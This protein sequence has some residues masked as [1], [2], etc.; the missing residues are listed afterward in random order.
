MSEPSLSKGDVVL[1]ARAVVKRFPGIVALD[2]VTFRAYRNQV[3]VLIGENGAGKS[4]LMRILAGV[5][6]ADEGE[7]L[8]DGR[9]I[10]MQSPRDATAHGISIV[11]QELATFANLNIS[12]NI[13]AGRELRR[14]AMFV[15]EPR[16][17]ARSE[18]AL[19]RL[20][21]PMNVATESASLPLGCR[22]V[23]EIARSLDQGSRILILD[24]P[25]SA[26][27]TAE[28]ESL[29]DVIAHLK[30]SGVTI[31]YISHRLHELLHLGDQFTVLRSGRVVGEASRAEVT[32]QWIVERMSGR[33]DDETINQEREVA[34]RPVVLSV[35]NL[36]LRGSVGAEDSQVALHGLS[37]SVREGEILGIYG[38]LGAGRTELLEALAGFRRMDDGEIEIRGKTMRIQNVRSALRAGIALL[39]EDRQRDGL[40]QDLSIRENVI[41]SGKRGIFLSQ[42]GEIARVQKLVSELRIATN[43]LELPVTTL[44]GGN[45]QKVL[46]ARCLMCSPKVLLLDEPTRGIDV[47]AKSEIYAILRRLAGKGIG[48]IFASSEIEETRSLAN[49]VLVLC[50]GR[51]AA[52]LAREEATDER[53]FAAA[54]PTVAAGESAAERM[55]LPERIA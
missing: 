29:L 21:M 19:R 44:S 34:L 25:T 31:I 45:Q 40:F 47:G 10:Q 15:D 2:G 48:I 27:S 36:S 53:L 46:L 16:Q 50:Q 42:A 20:R 5:D 28:T 9:V 13:F 39:P 3:N 37:F 35:K 38:L 12:E 54:S 11:H 24:E 49:R 26:L 8:L 18:E 14:S 30:R 1:E 23:V 51:F 17:A 43:D 7:L 52:E 32:R 22:Q 33:T 6:T 4:T 55:S 41:L